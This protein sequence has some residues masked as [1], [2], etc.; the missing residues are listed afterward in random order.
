MSVTSGGSIQTQTHTIT[1]AEATATTATI[2]VGFTVGSFVVQ[3]LRSN[4]DVTSAASITASGKNIIVASQG[5]YTLT[6]G[7]VVNL[8]VWA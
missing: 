6:S 1:S 4:V 8:V 3:I 7:D 2:S 5:A